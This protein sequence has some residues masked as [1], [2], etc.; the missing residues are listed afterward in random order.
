[1]LQLFFPIVANVI[2]T[3][4]AVTSAF[5]SQEIRDSGFV[6]LQSTRILY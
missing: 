1:M 6:S 3:T 2:Y 4:G 5:D